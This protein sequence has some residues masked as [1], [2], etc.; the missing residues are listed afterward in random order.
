MSW[1]PENNLDDI[2]LWYDSTDA[3]SMQLNGNKLLYWQNKAGFYTLSQ[4]QSADSPTVE[5]STNLRVNKPVVKFTATTLG[6]CLSGLPNSPI[7]ARSQTWFVVNWQGN[8]DGVTENMITYGAGGAGTW[9]TVTNHMA[10]PAIKLV[11]NFPD[12]PIPQTR[13]TW[14][15]M[16]VDLDFPNIY[17]IM[18]NQKRQIL[19]TRVNGVYVDYK[20]SDTVPLS[21]G[22]PLLLGN[23]GTGIKWEGWIGEIL[24]TDTTDTH[25]VANIESYLANKWSLRQDLHPSHPSAGPT[26]TW[27]TKPC[28]ATKYFEIYRA[29][30]STEYVVPLSSYELVAVVN[31]NA[32]SW[33]DPDIPGCQICNYFVAGANPKTTTYPP[34]GYFNV[35]GDLLGT[36]D[37]CCD[38]DMEYTY[39]APLTT[40]TVSG[41]YQCTPTPT[42]TDVCIPYNF[43]I[44]DDGIVY[45][46][47]FS[48]NQ[49]GVKYVRCVVAER[50]PYV[51]DLLPTPIPIEL[52]RPYCPTP[53]P[54]PTAV[55]EELQACYPT[56]TPTPTPTAV[57]EELEPCEP[58]PTP[59]PT[60]PEIPE[61]QVTQENGLPGSVVGDFYNICYTAGK[62]QARLINVP[63][64]KAFRVQVEAVVPTGAFSYIVAETVWFDGT[65]TGNNWT[66]NY[67]IS[68]NATLSA[69]D[70]FHVEFY[71]WP[72]ATQVTDKPQSHPNY[73]SN[74]STSCRNFD[75]F[76]YSPDLSGNF[77][78]G[79]VGN[80]Y[81]PTP[82]PT[83]TPTCRW[84]DI[85][86][87]SSPASVVLAEGKF[88][89]SDYVSVEYTNL[90]TGASGILASTQ[91]MSPLPGTTYNISL[92]QGDEVEM[93]ITSIDAGIFPP[94]T[95]DVYH[96]NQMVIDNI[97]INEGESHVIKIVWPL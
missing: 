74:N 48:K 65:A 31:R 32:R 33:F 91:L 82:T 26:I 61:V 69:Y 38:C 96:D 86:V 51:D 62:Y 64:T 17:T 12:I 40:V 6:A 30:T 52:N 72:D 84:G 20:I 34:T 43:E 22:L 97:Y 47:C 1:L 56:P 27:S 60:C 92:S 2:I 13:S 24:C 25:T 35:N 50:E 5:I 78:P 63:E 90:T 87:S 18:F 16:Q 70:Y 81:P 76:I 57:L 54:T 73:I 67:N 36:K 94:A 83:P 42:P 9:R 85:V 71:S 55:L 8:P 14:E 58:T 41:V 53:T 89:D 3:S 49:I 39:I 46:R 37:D 59:T 77:N 75:E 23:R 15:R 88:N 28:P 11:K 29:C 44:G 21:G 68:A 93:K 10:Q 66:I 45:E 7:P 80:M 19:S 4:S 79:C 95:I